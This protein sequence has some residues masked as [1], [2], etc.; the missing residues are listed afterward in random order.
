[1]KYL[2]M[3]LLV[4]LF[5]FC[6]CSD[7]TNTTISTSTININ[8]SHTDPSDIQQF[9]DA[10]D[11]ISDIKFKTNIEIFTDTPE[12]ITCTILNNSNNIIE[13]GESYTLEKKENNIWTNVQIHTFIYDIL[14]T[15]EPGTSKEMDYTIK[16]DTGELPDGDYRIT[17]QAAED[18]N[19]LS[20]QNHALSAEFSIKQ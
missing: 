12:K 14:Y 2:L 15:L 9:T 3:I 4:I 11:N 1:M 5:L 17:I 13:F 8:P 6:G 10:A 16:H 20:A 18:D 19:K 7:N